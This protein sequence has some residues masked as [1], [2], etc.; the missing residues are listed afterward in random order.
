MTNFRDLVRQMNIDDATLVHHHGY[1]A[2]RDEGL[3]P[4]LELVGDL[5]GRQVAR[6]RNQRFVNRYEAMQD[7]GTIDPYFAA[8]P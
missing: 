2:L 4:Q 7:S 8:V 5:Y 3:L 1:L 6:Q